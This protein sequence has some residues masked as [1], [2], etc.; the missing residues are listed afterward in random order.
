M[1]L[2]CL[3]VAGAASAAPVFSQVQGSPFATG[4]AGPVALAFSPG[5]K[6]LATANQT[7]NTVSVFS[8]NPSTGAL[9]PVAGSPFPIGTTHGPLSVAFS[10]S[11]ALLATAN[12][13]SSSV[14]VFS[15]NPSTGALTP[16][17]GSPFPIGATPETVAFSPSG[18]LLATSNQFSNSVSVFSV[19]SSTG[20]LTQVPSSPF[21]TGSNPHSANF[22]PSGAFLATAN[23]GDNDVSMF[24]VNSSTGALTSVGSP[25]TTGAG[26]FTAVF[27]P[28]GGLL[29]V[30]NHTDNTV[31]AFSVNSSTGALTPVAG[32]PFATG[33]GPFDLGFSPSGSLLATSNATDNTASVFAVSSSSGVL[34]SVAG[35]PFATGQSPRHPAFS[36]SG[37]LLA[38]ANQTDNT[39][40]MFAVGPPTATIAAPGGG[41]TY[42]Q[43][44]TVSTSFS[45]ADAPYAPGIVSCTDSLG[46]A[47][48]SGTLDTSTI[49]PHT[50]TVTATS[51]DGQTGTQSI[52]YTVAL[53]PSASISSPASGGTY[54]VG[55]SVQTNFSCREGASGPG[56]ASCVDSNGASGGSGHL[57]TSTTGSQTYTVTTTSSDGQTGSQSITYTV[58][59]APSVSIPSPASG[60]RY[61]LAQK[62]RA[63]Y[64]CHD[65]VAGPGI[66]SCVGTVRSGAPIATTKPGKHTFKVRAIS[67]DGQITTKAVTYQVTR[68]RNQLVA[69]PR[70]KPNSNGQFTVT[71]KVPGPG[72]VD[73]LVT[74][75]NDNLAHLAL[76]PPPAPILLQPAPGRFIFARAHASANRATTLRIPV[77]PNPQGQRLVAHHTYQVT[78][79]L[80][81]TYTP[82]G[83]RPH[84]IG[85]Y[86]LHL[87]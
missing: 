6:V 63:R 10:P 78:L 75:W 43:N 38:I 15:V 33:R 72:R 5:G 27:S 51:S 56:I 85:H 37:A 74:A 24:S 71:V 77:N 32:S 58:A 34:S 41:S 80:W 22:S 3:C 57:G 50:Y 18:G 44:A 86:G 42:T 7:D 8:V 17:A 59:G 13:T 64:S 45:C 4:G 28:S 70:L 23:F 29:D 25:T 83:G 35:S 1:L 52:T 65:G 49:G 40:S 67:I 82:T 84:S 39:I 48:A 76:Q 66:S 14:S 73:I 26:P 53:A 87:P 30:S 2:G 79:R 31:S 61:R 36:P 69:P 9:T 46:A 60:A 21:A 54:G 81:V 12:F 62:V 55:Q 68:P 20:A 19:N 11:G 16:V 47:A